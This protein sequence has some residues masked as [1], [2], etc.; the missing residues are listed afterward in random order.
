MAEFLNS[1]KDGLS[2]A[3][4]SDFVEL[5]SKAAA[6]KIYAI[7]LVTDSYM[8]SLYLA[9]GTEQSLSKQELK[10]RKEI[11]PDSEDYKAVLRW[12]PAEWV[13][14]NNS[15]PD[16]RLRKINNLLRGNVE[17]TVEFEAAFYG[18]LS[19]ALADLDRDGVLSK[20]QSRN[21]VTL[22]MS[23]SDDDKA[24]AVED[25]SAKILNPP[26]VYER[27]SKRFD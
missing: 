11:N 19:D 20:R 22:F 13:Y 3:V 5:A 4:R 25:Y 12:T 8:E 24:E 17:H 27:F 2:G 1:L 14:D 7:A 18:V 9:I 26:S 23:I 10:Y 16:S 21:D 6:E 15:L